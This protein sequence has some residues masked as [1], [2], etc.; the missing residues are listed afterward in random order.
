MRE[1]LIKI[2]ACP[3][4]K[5]N[6]ILTAEETDNDAIVSGTLRCKS[7]CHDYVFENTIPNLLHPEKD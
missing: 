4:C 7:C 5:G 6:L 2:L 3:I 1:S